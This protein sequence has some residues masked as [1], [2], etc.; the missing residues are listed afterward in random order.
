[1]TLKHRDRKGRFVARSPE[2][3]DEPWIDPNTG[4]LWIISPNG[5]ARKA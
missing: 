1:M 3:K 5:D 2:L 4:I